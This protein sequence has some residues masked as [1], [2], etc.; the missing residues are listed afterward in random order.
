MNTKIRKTHLERSAV[1]YLRQS[2]PIQVE[3]NRESTVW[4]YALADRASVLGWDKSQIKVL[5]SDLGK[6]G[7]TTTGREDFHQLMAAVGLGEVGAVFALEASRFSRSQADWHKLLDI[8]ALTD[9]LI[10]DQDGIYDPNDFNDRVI[11][12][13]K[14]T[15]SHTELHG[16]RLRLQGAKLNKAKKGELRCSPPTGY[17]YG[18]EGKLVL[19]PDEGV[20]AAIQLAFQQFRALGTAFGVMRYFCVNQ[21]PFPRRRW[22]PGQIG[23]L[24][25]GRANLSRITTLL[26]NPTYTGT[27][28][29]GRR[30]SLNVIESGQVKRVKIQLLPQEEWKVIIHNAHEA[31][32]SWDEYLSNREQLRQNSPNSI[33]DGCPSRARVGFALLQGLVICGK[34]GRR[35]SP[36]YHG[37]G[38][39][40]AAY[41]CTQA[42]KGL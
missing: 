41:E 9:T 29:Y 30:R 32:I 3:F 19:D 6:S 17:V 1:V 40:R 42:R 28:V 35:M 15:W 10:I 33:S 31:Y 23:T 8:C 7:Q 14:G 18:Q 27:Y 22:Q 25:W 26:H 5:D 37:T 2:T 21:I 34:C 39:C 38:G 12:G 4:Q 20:V 11:L 16:M 13:F 36:R 24:H